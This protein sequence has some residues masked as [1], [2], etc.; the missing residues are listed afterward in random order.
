MAMQQRRRIGGAA[1]A[2]ASLLA[3]QL[4]INVPAAPAL[5]AL[6]VGDGSGVLPLVSSARQ[7]ELTGAQLITT[8]AGNAK[9]FDLS[10]L[11][12]S[13]GADGDVLATD[14]DGNLEWFTAP[15][16]QVV[17]DA[18]SAL[19]GNGLTATPIGLTVASTA[20][21]TAGIDNVNPL[22][23]LRL[24]EQLGADRLTLE[25]TAQTVVPAINELFDLITAM[26]GVVE[27]VG[28][29]D[30]DQDEVTPGTGSPATAGALPAAAEGNKGWLLIVSVAGTGTGNAP[31]VAIAVGD[32]L[33]SDGSSWLRLDI[34]LHSVAAANVSVSTIT[35]LTASNVQ[36]AL[37][38]IIAGGAV[39][40]AVD[41]TSITG[42]GTTGD[43][44][45]AVLDDGTY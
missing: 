12:I 2:P 4:A 25:T 8:G 26:T 1:A 13:G 16:A 32:W 27:F 20:Q 31:A 28:T 40:V 17:V 11:K 45:V 15:P 10:N 9:T 29:Y 19:T 44:L 5:S 6:F 24:R 37:A 34:A 7:L 36:A 30:A 3:G 18:A 14:G 21:V 23:S 41:G 38:E 22:T 35:G 43:P 39:P 42:D 33:I